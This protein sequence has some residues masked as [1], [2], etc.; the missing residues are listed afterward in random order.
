MCHHQY[1]SPGE[2]GR[3]DIERNQ[4]SGVHRTQV[5]GLYPTSTFHGM[6]MCFISWMCPFPCCEVIPE[7][8]P[9]S[10][11]ADGKFLDLG[12]HPE[13]YQ[14]SCPGAETHTWQLSGGTTVHGV[15]QTQTTHGRHIH[16]LLARLRKQRPQGKITQTLRDA[17]TPLSKETPTGTDGIRV[18]CILL[19]GHLKKVHISYPSST[20]TVRLPLHSQFLTASFHF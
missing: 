11:L 16:S 18:P 6:C 2:A 10:L 15:A 7:P 17:W 4:S 9:P 8:K 5:G 3:W 13:L 1:H 19:W 12:F 20:N 14:L